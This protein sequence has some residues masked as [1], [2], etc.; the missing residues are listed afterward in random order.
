M[1]A[2]FVDFLVAR[3]M[4]GAPVKVVYKG[5][6]VFKTRMGSCCTFLTYALLLVNVIQ[7]T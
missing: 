2:R 6:N 5:S 3:D 4:Y 7:L 1:M